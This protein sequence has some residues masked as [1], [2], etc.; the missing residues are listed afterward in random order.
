MY[1]N[2]NIQVTKEAFL[3]AIHKALKPIRKDVLAIGTQR[4]GFV[5]HDARGGHA[6]RAIHVHAA[7]GG[8]THTNGRARR[9]LEVNVHDK[10]N[11]NRA[12]NISNSKIR[13]EQFVF[14]VIVRIV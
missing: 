11:G 3:A 14:V 8:A 6:G 12:I 10:H 4:N 5:A 13:S 9:E 7:S 1:S 2:R